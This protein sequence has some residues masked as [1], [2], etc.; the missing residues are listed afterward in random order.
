MSVLRNTSR[1]PGNKATPTIDGSMT[2]P[3]RIILLEQ[4]SRWAAALRREL[5]DAGRRLTEVRGE[6]QAWQTAEQH[7]GSL[8]LIDLRPERIDGQID[9]ITRLVAEDPAAV[10]VTAG[11]QKLSD[12]AAEAG[13]AA[14]LAG[15]HQADWLASIVRRF[16]AH[17]PVAK[18][19]ATDKN[20][21]TDW[22]QRLPW[23]LTANPTQDT[24]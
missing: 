10:I 21:L 20:I 9:L 12:V 8:L 2:H 19:N 16:L 22:R 5:P 1:L 13:A 17:T 24:A 7:R 4:R 14:H 23:P 3:P 15:L 18:N 11:E 6:K